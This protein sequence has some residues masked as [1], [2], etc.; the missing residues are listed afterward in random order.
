MALLLTLINGIFSAVV[1]ATVFAGA[2]A[3]FRML[4]NDGGKEHKRHDLA[5]EQL[6][7]ARDEFNEN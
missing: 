7:R 3:V 1:N 5:E 2:S 6:Q 4:R